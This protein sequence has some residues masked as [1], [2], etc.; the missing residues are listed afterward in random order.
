MNDVTRFIDNYLK[1]RDQ[2]VSGRYLPF[3]ILETKLNKLSSEFK[4]QVLGASVLGKEVFSVKLGSGKKK[5][6]AWSQMHGNESTT[7]KAIFDLFNFFANRKSFP[8]AEKVF[9]ELEILILPMLN[10][11]GAT[12]YTRENARGEDLN[13]DADRLSQPESVILRRALEDFKPDFCFNLH[14]QRSIFGVGSSGIP[15]GISF[16]APAMNED[17]SFPENRILA[18]NLISQISKDLSQFIQGKIARFDDAFNLNC[19]GD[20]FQAF[21]VPTILFEAGHFSGDY[22]RETSR[23]FMAA[24][25]FSGLLH[26]CDELNSDTRMEEYD[27][28]PQNEKNFYDIIIRNAVLNNNKVDVGVQFKEELASGEINF[29]PIVE[30]TG[31]LQNFFGH[32]EIDVKNQEIRKLD[33]SSIDLKDEL[34]DFLLKNAIINLKI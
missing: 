18:A 30:K 16:L 26:L 34:E 4:V 10:P 13:R 3:S 17:L 19:T 1:F 2:S 21:G 33:G 23:K 29:T 5:V 24:A 25:I 11:D 27:L 14:D 32:R 28:I 22:Q 31:N 7:T 9:S 8:E 20:R 12:A 6:L 15:A